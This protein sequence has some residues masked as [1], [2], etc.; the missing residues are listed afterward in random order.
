M[1]Q[2]AT[3]ADLA[4]RA[5]VSVSTIDR[6]LNSPDRVRAATAAR[7]LAAAEELQF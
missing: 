4:A 7:V 1:A 5:G 6:I 2:R 3:I